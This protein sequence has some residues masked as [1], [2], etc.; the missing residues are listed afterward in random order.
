IVGDIECAST[1]ANGLYVSHESLYIGGEGT[2]KTPDG[3]LYT[4]LHKFALE[5]DG[6]TYRASGVATGRLPWV[7]ASYF[8]DEHEERLRILTSRPSAAGIPLH[9]LTVL[10]ETAGNKLEAMSIL[11]SPE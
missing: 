2:A 11:P 7:N 4:V 10:E 3:T 6:V 5:P 8:M 9:A 1:N